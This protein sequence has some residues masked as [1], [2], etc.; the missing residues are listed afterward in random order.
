MDQVEL[1]K[2]KLDRERKARKEA[3]RILEKK[4]LEL[5]SKNQKL[6]ELISSKNK[7]LGGVSEALNTFFSSIDLDQAFHTSLAILGPNSKAD[8]IFILL[9][10]D[11]N[12]IKKGK[13]YEWSAKP[14]TDTSELLKQND[15][16]SVPLF[17]YAANE[18]E[19]KQNE[20]IKRKL[21]IK[22]D[23]IFPIMSSGVL[24]GIFG[25]I[26]YEK[27]IKWSFDENSLLQAFSDVIGSSLENR[28]HKIVVEEQKRFYENILN[29]IP[30][31]LV[32]FD[33]Q[34][35]YKYINPVAI[36]DDQTRSWL[37]DKDD[38][39]YVK[40]RNKDIAIAHNRRKI[41]NKVLNSKKAYSFEEKALNALGKVEW[42]YRTMYPVLNENESE[43]DMV[44]GYALDITDLK[45]AQE[46]NE[47]L[48]KF[49]AQNP[50]PIIRISIEGTVLFT[51]KACNW[52]L[53]H[54]HYH[55]NK[56]LPNWLLQICFQ[57]FQNA[58]I[59]RIEQ[60][61]LDCTYSFTIAPDIENN[62]INIYG[63]DITSLVEAKKELNL[64]LD[65]TEKQNDRLKNFTHIVTHNLRSH[66]GGIEGML[67]LIQ[68]Q[69]PNVYA[70]EYVKMLNKAANNLKETINHLTESVKFGF[71]AEDQL[72]NLKL[73]NIINN[74]IY[75][76]V[77]TLNKKEISINNYVDEDIFVKALPAYLDSIIMNLLTNA[78][79]YRSTER[80]SFLNIYTEYEKEY[81][82]LVFEDNG[83]GIDLDKH[84]DQLFGMHNT[85]HKNRDSRG[86]GLAITKNQIESMGGTIK[87]ES[88]VNEGSKFIVFFPRKGL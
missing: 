77:T 42:K 80:E 6:E 75:S 71:A 83:L 49:P 27:E 4:S 37:I 78:I 52:L 38:Y 29:S 59:E 87:V 86:I 81:I 50:N 73:T 16:S 40:F 54:W 7:L 18:Y 85:F 32:V 13:F 74:N 79:K 30:S 15:S 28:F 56:Q 53:V 62:F 43:V 8:H 67:Y 25:P 26:V 35:K 1:L 47:R 63:L 5:Y 57:S 45:K 11:K 84:K 17:Q 31:D 88:V 36:K 70:N 33:K 65:V 9:N 69:Y 34:H 19:I 61:I 23:N 14:Y 21:N 60:E 10:E 66:S 82:K 2:R 3:E 22:S 76:A 20:E 58:K 24:I 41:F 64:L 44:I 68:E 72:H 48:S 12:L 51:N 55:D 39:D 46:E